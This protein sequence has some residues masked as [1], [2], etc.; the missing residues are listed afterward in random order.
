MKIAIYTRKS[1]ETDKGSSIENQI[2]I[3]KNY[4]GDN[5][6]EIFIDEGW[7]GG[8]TNRPEFQ[9]MMN[10]VKKKRFDVIAVYKLDRISRN[11]IDFFKI[12]EILESNNVKFVSVTEGFDASTP[13]GRVLMTLLAAFANLERENIKQRVK[14][15]MKL[16]GEKGKWSGGNAPIGYEAY[17]ST[18]EH[19]K[20]ASY[21]RIKEDEVQI[22]KDIYDLYLEGIA[23]KKIAHKINMKYNLKTSQRR[24]GNVLYSPIY[25]EST[26]LTNTWLKN[27]GY[28]VFGEPD[29]HGYL[30]YLKSHIDKRGMKVLNNETNT[31]AAVSKHDPIISAEK[32]LK[33]QDILK[34]RTIEARPRI[35]Q[36]S[37]L[38]HMVKCPVCKKNYTVRTS[39][40]RKDGSSYRV[41]YQGCKCKSNSRQVG[42]EK[43]ESTVLQ[44]LSAFQNKEIL[45]KYIEGNKQERHNYDKEI[46]GFTNRILE[47]DK[48]INGLTEKLALVKSPVME[49]LLA[50]IENEISEKNELQEALLALEN[51]KVKESIDNSNIDVIHKTITEFITNFEKLDISEKQIY[52]KRL[53]KAVYLNP[54]TK[55]ASIEL[56]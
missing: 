53:I 15:N 1:I 2:Q 48:I 52:I 28:D 47:K 27:N 10:L 49:V 17:R 50:K 3:C 6:F 43:L 4:F 24:I 41:F 22:V 46:L 34:E 51:K 30:T 5:D 35:S 32:W 36:Y 23:T 29:G 54:S 16:L 38:S 31:I 45:K 40:I 20:K 9:K 7:S 21:L 12:Y 44:F 33:V 25:A 42:V 39:Y 56:V 14:D 8:N 18:D 55:K 37:Y 11:I 19:G 13:I 26:E